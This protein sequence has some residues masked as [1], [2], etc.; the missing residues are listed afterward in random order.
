[1]RISDWSSDVCSSDLVAG[2]VAML[3]TGLYTASTGGDEKAPEAPAATKLDMGAGR[4][5][6][7]LE[8]KLRGDLKKILDGQTWL[9]NRVT[10]LEEGTVV[11]VTKPGAPPDAPPGVHP[12]PPGAAPHS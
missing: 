2:V 4:R 6:D 7:S 3:G 5:G 1:M 10:A 12:P 8:T 11:P 9:A